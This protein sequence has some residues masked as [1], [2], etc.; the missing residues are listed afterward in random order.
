MQTFCNCADKVVPPFHELQALASSVL[1][2]T[3]NRE[4]GREKYENQSKIG[5]NSTIFVQLL[6][7]GCPINT[8]AL[9]NVF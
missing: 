8:N 9:K 2:V 4:K 7:S 6:G 1:F 5:E 3:Q